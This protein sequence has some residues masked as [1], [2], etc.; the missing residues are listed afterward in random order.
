MPGID[1]NNDIGFD[2]SDDDIYVPIAQRRATLLGNKK[3]SENDDR[4]NS[5]L[6]FLNDDSNK[7]S[8][9][10]KTLLEESQVILSEKKTQGEIP[11]YFYS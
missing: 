11:A 5:S 4:P 7:A 2:I 10:S 8:T 3:T 1:D 9:S 6:D